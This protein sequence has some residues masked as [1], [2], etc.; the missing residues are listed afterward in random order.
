MPV[1]LAQAVLNGKRPAI[2]R[3]ITLAENNHPDIQQAI[4]LL[5]PHT[6]HAHLVGI[7]G[8]PGA[9]KSSLANELTKAYRR[10]GRTVAVLAVDPTSPFSGGAILGDRIRMRDL[11]GDSGVFIR[12]MASRGNMGGLAQ[13]AY[14]A[15]KIFDAAGFDLIIIETV[16]AGQSEVEIAGAAHTVVVVESPGQGDDIQAIKAG[17]F[18]IADIFAVNKA[19][20][21]GL[22]KTVSALKMM[23]EMDR[24]STY[25]GLHHHPALAPAQPDSLPA[26]GWKIPIVPTVAS[27]GEGIAELMQAIDNHRHHLI[28][29]AE[30]HARNRARLTYEMEALIQSELMN[31]FLA[32]LSAE[33]YADIAAKLVNKTLTPYN[34]MQMILET[35]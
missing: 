11:A 6:G 22:T 9:G 21:P 13:A 23:L 19:D 33:D 35:F 10:A 7:T 2:A 24:P 8:S 26:N 4:S 31:R 16:G 28:S 29:S 5:Y 14:N 17:I 1:S 15:I 25:Y 12:S 32:R 34:A 20:R 30:L 18:E 3:L 27:Q